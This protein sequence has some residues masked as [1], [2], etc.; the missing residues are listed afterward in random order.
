MPILRWFVI[1]RLW[2]HIA[3]LYTKFDNSRF[4]PFRDMIGDNKK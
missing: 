3:Y 2:F 4:S 1:H